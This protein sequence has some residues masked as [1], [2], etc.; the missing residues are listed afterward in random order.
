MLLPL[1]LSLEPAGRVIDELPQPPPSESLV[2]ANALLVD[3]VHED[4]QADSH[5]HMT[6][7]PG[8]AIHELDHEALGSLEVGLRADLVVHSQDPRETTAW[9]TPAFVV[10]GGELHTPAEWLSD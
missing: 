7:Q 9:Q 6:F 10:L 5:T 2:L 8:S 1:M 3:G 4:Q